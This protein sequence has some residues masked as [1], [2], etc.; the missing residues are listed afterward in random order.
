VT[1]IKWHEAESGWMTAINDEGKAIGHYGPQTRDKVI[2]IYLVIWD[3]K[4]GEILGSS[5]SGEDR[6]SDNYYRSV[7]ENQSVELL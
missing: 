6:G 1:E 3:L 4:T 7:I 5:F 2:G